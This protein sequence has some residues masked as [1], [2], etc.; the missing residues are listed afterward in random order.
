L[1]DFWNLTESFPVDRLRR[2]ME[3]LAI[4][5][6]GRHLGSNMIRFNFVGVD[7]QDFA[8]HIN[9]ILGRTRDGTCFHIMSKLTS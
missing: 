3:L 9:E 1:S 2:S 6:L 4:M 7:D 8:E 5:L